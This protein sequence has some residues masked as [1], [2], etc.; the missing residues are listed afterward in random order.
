MPIHHVRPRSATFMRVTGGVLFAA[1]GLCFGDAPPH[2]RAILQP[3]AKP[4]ADE[5]LR[6]RHRINRIILCPPS[7][8]NI[9]PAQTSF[10]HLWE[11]NLA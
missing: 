7:A 8:H 4:C 5:H 10:S 11:F 9:S 3:T 6:R 2:D 1:V